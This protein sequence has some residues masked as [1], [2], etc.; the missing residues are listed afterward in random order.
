MN[1][2]DF[3]ISS[4]FKGLKKKKKTHRNWVNNIKLRVHKICRLGLFLDSI[5]YLMGKKIKETQ[6]CLS[7]F[8]HTFKQSIN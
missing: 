4:I 8:L 5:D 1:G 3:T 2:S 7:V 6:R